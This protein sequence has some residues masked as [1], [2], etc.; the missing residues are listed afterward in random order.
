[1]P[2]KYQSLFYLWPLDL[3]LVQDNDLE[4]DLDLN[5]HDP[6]TLVVKTLTK[7]TREHR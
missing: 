2:R 7:I 6:V 4:F 5:K 1:M 3:G